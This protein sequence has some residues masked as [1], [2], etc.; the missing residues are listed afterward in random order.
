M[1]QLKRKLTEE[2]LRSMRHIATPDLSPDGR[3]AACVAWEADESGLFRPNIL[4]FDLKRK[5]SKP[6]W[7]EGRQDLPLFSPDGKT[8]AFLG[9]SRDD[10]PDQVW[11]LDLSSSRNRRL[12]TLRYGVSDFAWSPDSRFIALT[13]FWWAEDEAAGRQFTE[14]TEKEKE[15]WL[16]CFHHRPMV[17][18]NLMYKSDETYGVTD[19][20]CRHVCLVDMKTGHIQNLSPGTTPCYRPSW[21][22]DGKWL[23]WYGKPYRHIR[24]NEKALFL[25]DLATESLQQLNVHETLTDHSPA[26]FDRDGK[27]IFY[28]AINTGPDDAGME[29]LFQY[30]LIKQT[31]EKL[32]PEA[33][34]CHGLG[35]LSGGRTAMGREN[36]LFQ[37]SEDG[38]FIYFLSGCAPQVHV[39]RI[40][41][42]DPS[43]VESVTTGPYSV[44]AFCRPIGSSQLMTKGDPLT[45]AELY[46]NQTRLSFC[47][48]FLTEIN[49][50]EPE[51]RWV[52]STDGKVF[53]HGYVVKPP[54]LEPGWRCPAVLYIHGGPQ[55]FYT[56]DFWFEAQL[57]AAR[58]LSVVYCDPRGSSGYGAS[59]AADRYAWGPE[60]EEDLFAFLDSVVS[61]GFIEADRIGVTG[62]SYGGWMTN[63]L[64]AKTDR[65][66]A[67]VTQRTLCNLATSYGTGDMGFIWTE[68]NLMTQMENF[69]KRVDKSP[70]TQI[71]RIRTPL[72]IL[73]GTHDYRC[74]FEQA[75]QL[76]IAMK[77]RNP[78]V[79]VRLVAFPGE[80]HE[81]S[82][83]GK[84]HFQ[85]A[86]LREMADWFE[87]FL[88]I[89]DHQVKDGKDADKK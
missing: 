52:P 65:F 75:E 84:V 82:R 20:S 62:G 80:N 23:L 3:R 71:D 4:M 79:P 44:H 2:D 47:N 54:D 36:P 22:G 7:T 77:D 69:M 48:L 14:M 87:R 24:E 30:D 50:S 70:I 67:A 45:P 81:I 73:H 16:F 53:I 38:Q 58:G 19:Q 28:A 8:L 37:Q 49:L 6:V 34:P 56:H 5:T 68:T 29:V 33:M 89:W 66:S 85:M 60:A 9:R 51:E 57:L 35:A 63:R 27:R 1:T 11:L 15:D 42:S 12:T 55:A 74:G 43:S 61:E 76:F 88:K 40:D 10:E 17:I 31:N 41:L 32:F 13:T 72:L 25:Y 86:H 26:L 46:V 64:I 21:S 78:D 39:Y 59:F 83:S 18:E